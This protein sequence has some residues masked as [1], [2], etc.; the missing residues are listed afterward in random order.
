M[1]HPFVYGTLKAA[2]RLPRAGTCRGTAMGFYGQAEAAARKILRAFEDTNSLPK[3][4]ARVF[5][6]RKDRPHC[7]NWSWGNQLLV[8]L[9]GYTDARGFR[10]WEQV[11]RR[12]KRGEKAFYILAPVT[13]KLLDE[14]T[15]EE[16][17]IVVGFRGLPVFGYEQTEGRPL[18][19]GDPDIEKWLE[20]LPLL[21]VAKQWGLSVGAYYGEGM[22]F[23]GRYRY[24]KGIDLGVKNLS[25]WCH[26]LVHA[27]DD[28]NGKLKE[29]GQHWRSETVAE[30][31]GAVL[32]EILGYKEEADLGGCWG[33]VKHYAR[34]E[35]MGATEAC[36]KVLD[37]TCAAVGLILDTAEQL[38]GAAG[39][40]G[41]IEE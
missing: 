2:V 8:I 9:H 38:Q 13:K 27:A 32:L 41:T 37:R 34:Q 16:R 17:V 25:A 33:Y 4:L 15:G 10:Q 40:A 29:R 5:I 24:G 36:M 20:S 35:K 23:L 1:K 7:R 6:R 31:G 3:P 39:R 26:E 14:E 30:L 19:S 28:R 12:V 21:D 18:P 22:G 11:G